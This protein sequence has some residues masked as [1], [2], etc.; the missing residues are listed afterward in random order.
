MKNRL[1]L[2]AFS[3]SFALTSNAQMKLS[4]LPGFE[5]GLQT[6]TAFL[7]GDVIPYFSPGLGVYAMQPLG[8]S[9]TLRYNLSVYQLKGI[10]YYTSQS[11]IN[12]N[13]TIE[14]LGY[15]SFVN[16]YSTR[17]YDLSIEG[18][19]VA[20]Y[21]K[22]DAYIGLGPSYH[23][24][25]VNYDATDAAGNLYDFAPLIASISARGDIN[26]ADLEIVNNILDGKYETTQLTDKNFDANSS[27][28]I[29]IRGGMSYSINSSFKIGLD[30]RFL[31]SL[32]DNLDGFKSITNSIISND[33]VLSLAITGSYAL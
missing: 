19:F 21:T 18:L 20:R 7:G 22:I 24:Y 28:G 16:N 23:A 32:K 8:S 29:S 12:S 13:R 27:F 15:T 5:I 6:G 31:F 1:L 10:N 33:Q 11:S 3:L 9:F 25:N 26:Q 17:F 14:E 4:D 30:A 2:L